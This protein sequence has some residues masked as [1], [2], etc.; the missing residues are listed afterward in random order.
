MQTR[1][2]NKQIGEEI[3]SQGLKIRDTTVYHIVLTTQKPDIWG[4]MVSCRHGKWLAH[5]A[6]S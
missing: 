5:G 2:E 3:G 6:A 4:C 1:R